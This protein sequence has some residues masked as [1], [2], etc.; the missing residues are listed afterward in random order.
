MNIESFGARP[1]FGI[2]TYSFTRDLRAIDCLRLMAQSGYRRFE[3]MMVPRH[4]WPSIDGSSGVGEIAAL[5]ARESLEILTV[6][7]PSLDINL[8]SSVPEM[9]AHSCKSIEAAIEVASVWGAKGVVLNPGKSNPVFPQAIE[10]L[11]DNFRRSLDYL[12]PVAG[13]AGVQLIVKNH[14][15]SFLYGAH[16]L[17][18]FFDDFGWEQVG[19]GYDFANAHFARE[20]PQVIVDIVDHLSFFYAADTTSMRFDH[21]EVG[22]GDVQWGVISAILRET[23]VRLP[24]ILEIVSDDPLPSICSSVSRLEGLDWPHV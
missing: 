12:V 18:R 1:E 20:D 16:E 4:F 21:A 5:L 10:Y 14:P 22:M 2:N 15:L 23:G 19:I 8:S 24:T 7:Q 13:R 6:N 11:L 9:R 3:V 17:S